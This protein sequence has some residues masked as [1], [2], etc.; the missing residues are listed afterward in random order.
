MNTLDAESLKLPNEPAAVQTL[1]FISKT[2]V[3]RH[4]FM[5]DTFVLLGEPASVQCTGA[6]C[7][8]VTAMRNLKQVMELLNKGG[9][10]GFRAG[11]AACSALLRVD[12]PCGLQVL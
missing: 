8:L 3:P 5:D 2:S 4:Y 10:A 11:R 12:I 9:F 7:S 6:I 1:G